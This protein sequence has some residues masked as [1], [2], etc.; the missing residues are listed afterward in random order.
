MKLHIRFFFFFFTES[1]TTVS[2]IINISF[3]SSTLALGFVSRGL[4][5]CQV[6]GDTLSHV[7]QWRGNHSGYGQLCV[8]VCVC[9]CVCLC[10]CLCM[11][12][13]NCWLQGAHLAEAWVLHQLVSAG[14]C[15]GHIH[16]HSLFLSLS[17]C[18]LSPQVRPGDI[19]QPCLSEKPLMNYSFNY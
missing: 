10:V 4:T 15:M 19:P 3:L 2:I 17:M 13:E 8:C 11:C 16:L 14:S 9:V 18:I 7:I 1:T 12:V 5:Y 6:I